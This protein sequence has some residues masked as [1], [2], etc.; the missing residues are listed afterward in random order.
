MNGFS[1]D[2][3]FA[4]VPAWDRVKEET[5]LLRWMKSK[6]KT[7]EEVARGTDASVR[8]VKYWMN[9]QALPC[10]V[11]AFKIE[12]YTQGKVPVAYW[13]G[14]AVGKAQWNCLTAKGKIHAEETD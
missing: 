13:L 10:L 5:L 3:P 2:S 8:S 14:T 9:G 6:R 4:K 7:C 12:A 1:K 11:S